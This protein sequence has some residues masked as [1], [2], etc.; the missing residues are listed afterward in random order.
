MLASLGGGPFAV[1]LLLFVVCGAVPWEP[2]R[3]ASRELRQGGFAVEHSLVLP[4]APETIYDA[5]SGDISGWWDHTFSEKPAKFVLEPK[6]GGG[7]WE[8][9]SASGD[10]VKHAE[11]I[12]AQRGK[13]LRFD[14]PLG[15][16]GHA[17]HM[18]CTYQFD[19]VGTDSTRLGFSAHASGEFEDGWPALVDGVWRHFLF[20]RFKPYVETGKH[21]KAAQSKP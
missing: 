15:L 2:A 20:E 6:P 9:F 18:V 12:Y 14:G 21:L 8:I 19:A 10:G 1:F 4:G 13:L 3:S 17:V 7:F 5:I 11:V 16:S